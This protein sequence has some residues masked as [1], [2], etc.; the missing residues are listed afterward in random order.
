[1]NYIYETHLH[2]CEASACGI[3]PGAEYIEFMKSR[4]YSGIIVTDHFFNGNTCISQDLPWNER[5]ERFYQGYENARKAAEGTDFS[6]FFGVEVNYDR[7]EFLLYGIDK[8]W[9]LD[10]PDLL[11]YSREQL[12]TEIK[13]IGGL[14]IQ[15][16]PFRERFYISTIHLSPDTCDGI[17]VYNA[18]NVSW[19]NALACQYAK[20]YHLPVIAGSDVHFRN[21]DAMGGVRC[22]RPLK[23][24]HDYIQAFK[25]GELEAVSIR[26]DNTVVPVSSL[27][28]EC[29]TEETSTL[30]VILHRIP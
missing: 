19:Q 9:L 15:A 29:I 7:D 5:I 12:Y 4:G 16:H 23:D 20:E 2:T 21:T 1:M 11:S 22:S 13:Q 30:P 6:V 18:G 27:E 10:R 8:Q 26:P 17:E 14:M 3:M 28:E 24:I 25:N